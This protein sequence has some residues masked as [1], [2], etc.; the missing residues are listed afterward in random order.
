[1][2]YACYAW[3]LNF[4]HSGIL[5]RIYSF[6]KFDSIATSN[7][8]F[9]FFALFSIN[10]YLFFDVLILIDAF[11]IPVVALSQSANPGVLFVNEN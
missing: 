11:P 10:C 7:I 9:F 1:M 3:L 8:C 5:P 6:E 2:K 4:N